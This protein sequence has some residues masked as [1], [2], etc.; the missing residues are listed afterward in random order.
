MRLQTGD[1]LLVDTEGFVQSIIDWFQKNDWNHAAIYVEHKG[2]GYAF[3]AVKSGQA[4]TPIEIYKK[5]LKSKED[6]N[7]L[8]CRPKA[9]GLWW[10]REDDLLGW[11][12]EK[13]QYPYEYRNLTIQQAIRLKSKDWL[14]DDKEIWIG[15]PQ[16]K[17]G[18]AFICG[19]LV[20]TA[21]YFFQGYFEDVYWKGAPSD[22]FDRKLFDHIEYKI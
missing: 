4:F 7:I 10:G 2:Q 5:R 8:V 22:I 12:M 19:E 20:M 21:Y 11:C 15:K 1:I 18:K 3:E 16:H 17:A 6:I 13:T 9:S 14:G